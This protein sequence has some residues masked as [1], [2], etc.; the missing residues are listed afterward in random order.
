MSLYFWS[1]TDFRM[2]NSS[3]SKMRPYTMA[4]NFSSLWSVSGLF[5]ERNDSQH[6]DTEHNDNEQ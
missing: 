2:W 6:N 4:D 1:E 3:L 5:C